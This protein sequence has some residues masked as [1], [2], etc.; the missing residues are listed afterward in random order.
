LKGRRFDDIDEIRSNTRSG[1]KAIPQNQ[2]QNCFEGWTRR[3]HRCIAS[4]GEFF[5]KRF[6]AQEYTQRVQECVIKLFL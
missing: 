5:L 1:L 3:W 6:I 4:Q 2:F